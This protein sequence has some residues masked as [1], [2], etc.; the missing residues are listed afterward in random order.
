MK[1]SARIRN[2]SGRGRDIP[3]DTATR[4]SRAIR[5]QAAIAPR[6]PA[7]DPENRPLMALSPSARRFGT[8]AKWLGTGSVMGDSSA[9]NRLERIFMRYVCHSLFL[10]GAD[11]CET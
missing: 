3:G 8:H 4:A 7:N 9:V 6:D 1:M 10:F 5:R 11:A 2:P